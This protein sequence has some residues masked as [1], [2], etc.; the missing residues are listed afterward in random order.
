MRRV[1]NT[2][3]H[4]NLRWLLAAAVLGGAFLAAP[5]AAAAANPHDPFPV[6]DPQR[7]EN[8]DHMTWDD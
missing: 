8:P 5:P 7:W 3:L 6:L 1:T 2:S 4:V